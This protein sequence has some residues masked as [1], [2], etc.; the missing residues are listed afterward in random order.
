SRDP[1]NIAAWYLRS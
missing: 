1:D